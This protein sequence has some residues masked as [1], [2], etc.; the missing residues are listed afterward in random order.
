[1]DV[2]DS[3]F[4][5]A[6]ASFDLLVEVEEENEGLII[7]YTTNIV[8]GLTTCTALQMVRYSRKHR[9]HSEKCQEGIME[10]IEDAATKFSFVEDTLIM[11]EDAEQERIKRIEESF[12]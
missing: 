6:K 2:V 5:F 10:L 12:R 3:A 9:R 1:M 7:L 8:H 11:L 4:D